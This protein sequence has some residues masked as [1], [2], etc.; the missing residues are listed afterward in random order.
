M[1][2][3]PASSRETTAGSAPAT[4]TILVRLDAPATSVTAPRGT[5]NAEASNKGGLG[6]FAGD[7][8]RADPNYERPGM[9]AANTW[10]RRA[11]TDPDRNPHNISVACSS[12]AGGDHR[13]PWDRLGADSRCVRR[14]R[15]AAW[16]R[17]RRRDHVDVMPVGEPT[18]CRTPLHPRAARRRMPASA[19]TTTLRCAARGASRGARGPRTVIPAGCGCRLRRPR[20]A[21]TAT[22]WWTPPTSSGSQPPAASPTRRAMHRGNGR[23]H[24]RG[25]YTADYYFLETHRRPDAT[26]TPGASPTQQPQPAPM[27]GTT[28]PRSFV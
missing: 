2:A 22:G 7:G 28:R 16:D 23:H 9:L 25:P 1:R 5:P 19:V 27:G 20:P 11:G 6:R 26:P 10:M 4:S 3:G 12:M 8:A 13:E 17:A 15:S 21:L 14:R 24:G 18:R